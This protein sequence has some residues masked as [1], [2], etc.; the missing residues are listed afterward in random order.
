MGFGSV[1][2]EEVKVGRGQRVQ[3]IKQGASH[4]AHGIG[5]LAAKPEF[6]SQNLQVRGNGNSGWKLVKEG[7][8]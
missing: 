7:G 4:T 3:K 8:A 1:S 5:T 6:G 2:E